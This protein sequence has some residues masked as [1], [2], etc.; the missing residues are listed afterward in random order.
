MQWPEVKREAEPI[1]WC[2]EAPRRAEKQCSFFETFL[3]FLR[4][5]LRYHAGLNG[6]TVLERFVSQPDYSFRD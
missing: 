3:E 2:A 6:T 1:A 4:H 5:P